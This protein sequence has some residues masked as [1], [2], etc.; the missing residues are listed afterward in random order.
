MMKR[1]FLGALFAPVMV[2]LGCAGVARGQ[3]SE[4]TYQ[5]RLEVSNALVTGLY[6]LQFGLCTSVSNGTAFT[7]ITATAVAVTNGFFTTN[8][9]FG[10]SVFN[11]TQYWLQLSARTNGSGTFQALSPRQPLTAA[12]YAIYSA[13][14]ATAGSVPS[15]GVP[16]GPTQGDYLFVYDTTT[17]GDT[18][19]ANNFQAIEFS[20]PSAQLSGW[21]LSPI[22]PS[23]SAFTANDA[24]LYLMHY[25]AEV[26]GPVGRTVTTR[27]I[28]NNHEITGSGCAQTL[29]P[30]TNAVSTNFCMG[31]SFMASVNSG[32][33]LTLQ[34]AA[35]G[36][37]VALHPAGAALAPTSVSMTV[38]RIK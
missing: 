38:I 4:F 26:Q 14:A 34:F 29:G 16:P 9:D 1:K 13:Y 11:G 8:L 33:V 37:G 5:G 28:L 21:T 27:A 31:T 15:A 2:L 7:N 32:D 17:Q 30:A 35:D 19:S 23:R 18:A 24:G 36:T 3:G 6:D 25:T 20:N 12:P 22:G 10:S